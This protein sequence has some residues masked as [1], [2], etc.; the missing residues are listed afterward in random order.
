MTPMTPI[1]ATTE[2][3]DFIGRLCVT[4]DWACAHGDFSSLRC[5]AQQLA[6]YTPEP[7]H[8]ELAALASACRT[9]PE[10]ATELW[11]HVRNLVYR[12]AT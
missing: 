4:G 5:V 6:A 10:R 8:C 12:E 9:E 3:S 7:I 1:A 2:V 11:D